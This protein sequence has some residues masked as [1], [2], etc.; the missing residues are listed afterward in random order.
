M[1]VMTSN[2]GLWMAFQ[3]KCQAHAEHLEC[4]G[5][6]AQASAYYPIAMVKAVVK[7][8]TGT[9]TSNEEKANISIAKDVQV[10]LL[11]FDED[12]TQKS[13]EGKA[14]EEDPSILTLTRQR[15]P[16]EQPTGKKLEQ[17]K[18]TMLRIHRA[19]GHPSMT[20]LQQVLRARNAPAWAVALAGELRCSECIEAKKPRPAPPASAGELPGLFDVFEVEFNHRETQEVQKAK[21]ILCRDRASRLAQVDLMKIHGTGSPRQLTCFA[22]PASGC[23]TTQHPSG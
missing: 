9:W 7:A 17:M 11:G 19:S 8:V 1:A 10:H 4:R 13:W 22:H 12:E 18:Q 23:N 16:T 5:H 15:Y 3:K 21:F 2:R 14:R 20:N 6:V